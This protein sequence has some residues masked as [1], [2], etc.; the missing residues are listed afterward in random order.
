MGDKANWTKQLT[1]K[2]S[3]ENPNV[4]NKRKKQNRTNR[5][6][7]ENITKTKKQRK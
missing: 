2:Y 5:D 4:K 3:M 7:K 6:L 1:R